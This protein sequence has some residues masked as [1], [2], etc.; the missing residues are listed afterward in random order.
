MIIIPIENYIGYL[1][2]SGRLKFN[3]GIKNETWPL[4]SSL[5]KTSISGPRIPVM[6]TLRFTVDSVKI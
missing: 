2:S 6:L 3:Q 1:I 4:F 5:W